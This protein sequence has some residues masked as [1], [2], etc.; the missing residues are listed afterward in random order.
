MFALV[1]AAVLAA[2]DPGLV[3]AC[4]RYRDGAAVDLRGQR[5]VREQARD[6]AE[7]EAAID[8]RQSMLLLPDGRFLLRTSTLYPG[9]IEF[10]FRTVGDVRGEDTV[11]ELQWR[12]G[13]ALS[14]DDA[15][16]SVKDAADLRL[17]LPS[18]T[19]C[20]AL[21]Y[22]AERVADGWRFSDPVGRA[23]TLAV[24]PDGA[25]AAARRDDGL[26]YLYD[27]RDPGS[28]KVT[29]E[30]SG[31]VTARWTLRPR[32]A[33]A[34]DASLLT[35]PDGYRSADPPGPLRVAAL[36]DGVYRVDGTPSGYHT[37]FVVG[38]R[39]IVLFDAPVGAKEAAAVRALI[40]QT[41]PGLAIGHVV[42]S[43]THRDHAAGL[44]AFAE[45]E[46]LT[47]VGGR[48]AL[49]RQ[50]GQAAPTRVREVSTPESLDLGGRIVRLYPLASSRHASTML[51]G[52]DEASGTLFQGDLFYLPERG[53]TPPAFST[54]RELDTLIA[55]ERL[56]VERIVGVHGRTAGLDDLKR[57]LD[58]AARGVDDHRGCVGFQMSQAGAPC[59]ASPA[60]DTISRRFKRRTKV[61][62]PAPP[63]ISDVINR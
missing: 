9:P 39:E 61:D 29:Q 49:E 11:D 52:L 59:R 56:R 17:R 43:H 23:V 3:K 44:P 51:V 27:A 8:D 55:S 12:D 1:L 22:G 28:I 42:I 31:H 54:G 20:D 41:A 36:D 50:L 57:A 4:G 10:R 2:K 32:P 24:R 5:Y 18:L 33:R 19:A 14:H 16:A 7:A 53:P 46:V 15:T 21:K 48:A 38:S 62:A 58:L 34:A 47:G 40:E 45:A 25:P 13:D 63:A 35:I 37:G 30:N 26:T 60:A 6:P